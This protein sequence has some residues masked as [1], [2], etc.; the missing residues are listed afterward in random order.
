MDSRDLTPEQARAARALLNWLRVRLAAKANLGE[1]VISEFET[2]L[3]NRHPA[4]PR[5]FE[6]H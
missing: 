4:L 1:M 6:M 5:L 3:R 2:G